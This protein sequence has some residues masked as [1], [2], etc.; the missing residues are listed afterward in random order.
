MGFLKGV[1]KLAIV[2]AKVTGK[3]S[4]GSA[5]LAAKGTMAVGT[6]AYNHREE[7]GRAAVTVTKATAVTVG[8][9]GYG[10][11]KAGE[12]ATKQV[13]SH[14]REIGGTAVGATKGISEAIADVSGHAFARESV[15]AP[16]IDRIKQQSAKYAQE[17]QRVYGRIDASSSRVRQRDVALDTLVVGGNTLAS[18]SG[19]AA[20]VPLEVEHAYQLAYP[21]LSAHHTFLQEVRS[22]DAG[23]LPG[24][25]DGVKGKLFE[26]KYVEYLNDGHLPA[27]Y[28]AHL[29]DSAT[30]AGWDIEVLGP[31]G[32][33][34]DLIQA[35]A[36]DSVAYVQTA[37]ERYP[38]IDVVTTEEVHSQ[39]I[40]AGLGDHVLDSGITNDALTHAVEGASDAAA[41]HFSWMP[42][43]LS[44]ALIAF[45]AY[46]KEGL[47]A[48]EKSKGFGER[49]VR[50]YLAYLAGGAVAVA[51][52]TWWLGMLGGMGSRLVMGAGRAKRDRLATLRT[53][54]ANNER[55][56]RRLRAQPSR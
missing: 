38:H 29:A 14:R 19:A 1:G 52:H 2:T 49:S 44:I 41:I 46:S 43:A 54:I 35:K 36:T 7:I 13:V 32:H 24:L 37:L 27:G 18:Y 11:Y 45:S 33:V 8:T 10:A 28:E 50:S 5:K 39:L 4:A 53:L 25:V 55:V 31:D 47:D 42:S 34:R 16:L 17:I 20:P 48:Y 51:T 40:M 30:Q 12:W 15:T 9:V 26:I 23:R 6:A 22:L 21:D 56:L 3:A